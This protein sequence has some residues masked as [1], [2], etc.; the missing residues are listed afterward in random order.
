MSLKHLR[1]LALVALFGILAAA[2]G[3]GTTESTEEPT[4]AATDEA[5]EEPTTEAATEEPTTEAATEEPTTEG[6]TE[7]PTTEGATEVSG[8]AGEADGV[9]TIGTMLPETGSPRVPRPTGD[10]GRADRDRRHQRRRRRPRRR[11]RVPPTATPGD[12][13]TDIASQTVD[14]H[15]AAGVDM[16]I[17]AA[18]SGVTFTVIDK[19][20]RRRRDPVLAGQHAPRR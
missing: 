13:S 18:S 10:R 5:T 3:G 19:H 2:C 4:A 11:R 8:A 7:E 20:H 16:I 14:R 15:L 6:A 1:T 17:G 9:L 12:T